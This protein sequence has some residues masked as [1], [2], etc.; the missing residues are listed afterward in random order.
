MVIVAVALLAMW[1]FPHS[2]RA[3][4]ESKPG[5]S[6]HYTVVMTEG[7]NLLVTDN[8]ANKVFF[9]P[10]RP[11]PSS[12]PWYAGSRVTDPGGHGDGAAERPR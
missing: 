5:A 2:L 4:Q 11:T 8:A 3:D 12:G 6:P 1:G 7:H 9:L 10:V